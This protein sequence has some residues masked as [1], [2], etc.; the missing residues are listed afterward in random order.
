MKLRAR[1]LLPDI[2]EHLMSTASQQMHF[3]PKVWASV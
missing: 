1:R 2:R 3:A